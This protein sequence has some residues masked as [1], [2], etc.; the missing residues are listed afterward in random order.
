MF[1]M[2][3]CRNEEADSRQVNDR[4]SLVRVGPAEEK[5]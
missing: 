4:I 3:D 2:A 5:S 1:G